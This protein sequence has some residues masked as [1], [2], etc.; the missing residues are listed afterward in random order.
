MQPVAFVQHKGEVV[1][2]VAVHAIDIQVDFLAEVE[3]H[4]GGKIQMVGGADRAVGCNVRVDGTDMV[5]AVGIHI[6]L[7]HKSGIDEVVKERLAHRGIGIDMHLAAPRVIESVE[8]HHG[9]GM[10]LEA[11]EDEIDIGVGFIQ[12]EIEMGVKHRGSRYLIA[13]EQLRRQG[14]V[15][16]QRQIGG[17]KIVDKAVIGEVEIGYSLVLL[18]DGES[19]VHIPIEVDVELVLAVAGK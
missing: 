6:A 5:P 2:E 3:A 4:L 16:L 9:T 8:H 12:P 18:R 13:D 1:V 10:N 15:V 17:R 19:V 14:A 11:R 7:S